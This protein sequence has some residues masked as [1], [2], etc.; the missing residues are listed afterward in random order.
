MKRIFNKTLTFKHAE[1]DVTFELIV[2][3]DP[4]FDVHDIEVRFETYGPLFRDYFDN[5]VAAAIDFVIETQLRDSGELD[6]IVAEMEFD[7]LEL[8]FER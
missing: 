4:A 7:S 3:N 2:C 8:T 5:G 6:K 1:V